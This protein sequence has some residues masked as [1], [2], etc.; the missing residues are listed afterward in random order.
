MPPRTQILS[1]HKKPVHFDGTDD[2]FWRTFYRM[3]FKL[4]FLLSMPVDNTANEN[5]IIEFFFIFVVSS[6]FSL[7]DNRFLFYFL[8]PRN[9]PAYTEC[10]PST[11]E[12]LFLKSQMDS[13]EDSVRPRAK[14]KRDEETNFIRNFLCV[15]VRWWNWKKKTKILRK[16]WKGEQKLLVENSWKTEI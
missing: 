5:I 9:F 10:G 3:E 16:K 1:A 6:L 14:T 11:R 7:I 15:I 13:G 2:C 4:A 12:V 8:L